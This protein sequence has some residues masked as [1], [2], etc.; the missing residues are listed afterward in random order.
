MKYVF[1]IL[2]AV[3]A[4]WS[5]LAVVLVPPDEA[6]GRA[7]LMW[8]S[9]N[10]PAR[11]EQIDN[12]NRLFPDCFLRLDPN[13]T[14]VQ[15]IIVQSCSGIGPDIIDVYGI[16]QLQT[17]VDAGILLD[18]TDVAKERGF[19]P[20]KTYAKAEGMLTLDGRQFCY[21][22]NVNVDIIIY[23]K[24][25]F[26]KYDVPYPP[27]D[28]VI[29][30]TEFIEKYAT[31]L[32]VRRK[33][34]SLP[35]CFGFCNDS[36]EEL[37]YQAGGSFFTQDG[38]RCVVDSPEAIAGAQ[39]HRDLMH[40]FNVSPNPIQKEGMSSEGG[41]GQGW[42][43][44]FG[45]Q[46]I[47][48]IKIGKWSLIRLRRFLSD[49]NELFRKRHPGVVIPTDEAECRAWHRKWMNEHEEPQDLPPA[50]L[51]AMHV[52]HFDG[53][54]PLV[55]L[56]CRSAAIN[57]LS[58]HRDKAVN[59]LSYLAGETYCQTINDGADALP[60]NPEF[61]TLKRQINPEWPGEDDLHDLTNKATDWG[62]TREVSP[63]VDGA[64]TY[65]FIGAQIDRIDADPRADVAEAMR[66]AAEDVNREIRKNIERDKT[67][68][69]R[70]ERADVGCVRTK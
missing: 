1:A 64:T 31:P 46:R 65:R 50:R 9:D 36:W 38:A 43:N 10:N 21:P 15:K 26:D 54:P 14:G 24:N 45:S 39:L 60:G 30:W 53:R 19:D 56:D 68:R 48:S 2:L 33:G 47:A 52:P 7:P 35:E 16:R 66:A 23:N 29:S 37:I 13:N 6:K 59:F 70:Y 28:R 17:Y 69:E 25:L 5:L 67:L 63:Y 32:T 44:F 55:V 61:A 3:L 58:P 27:T 34:K 57:K 20:S 62:Q 22:C 12:F 8:V 4:A 11:V 51:G 41:W 18:V 40:R 49:Q 42:I